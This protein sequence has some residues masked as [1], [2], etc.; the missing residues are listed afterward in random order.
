VIGQKNPCE[1]LEISLRIGKI[2]IKSDENHGNFISCIG[3]VS[4]HL[5]LKFLINDDGFLF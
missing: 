3:K 1:I 2:I 5:V 4:I